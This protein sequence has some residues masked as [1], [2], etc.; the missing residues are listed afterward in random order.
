[1]RMLVYEYISSQ[2]TAVSLTIVENHFDKSDRT[3]LYRTLKTFE[4]KGIVHKIDDGTGIP[5]YALCKHEHNSKKHNDL[6]LHFHC[7]KCKE[8]VCLTEHQIPQINLPSKFIPE[9]INML[10]KGVCDKCNE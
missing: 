1:M 4:D 5:K 6:H 7:T 3:T 2:H 10:I 8:T 9:N